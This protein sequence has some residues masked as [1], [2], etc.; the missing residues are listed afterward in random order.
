MV[1]PD[2]AVQQHP[3]DFGA[4]CQ[5]GGLHDRGGVRRTQQIRRLRQRRA[6]PGGITT[7][8]QI[9]RPRHATGAMP[10]QATG[11]GPVLDSPPRTSFPPGLSP[12]PGGLAGATCSLTR[13]MAR[14]RTCTK[15]AL[16]SFSPATVAAIARWKCP[17]H[18]S[19]IA[20]VIGRPS[21]RLS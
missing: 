10:H 21:W 17:S 20:G 12:R 14:E 15:I 4:A 2:A 11:R 19:A 6:E 13:A 8:S 7:V 9:P 18:L 5:C 3:H 1:R 16:R